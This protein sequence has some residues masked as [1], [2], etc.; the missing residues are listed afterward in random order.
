MSQSSMFEML[1]TRRLL[2]GNVTAGFNGGTNTF[3]V[4]GDNK[5]NQIVVEAE[6]G[7]YKVTGVN[8]TTVNNSTAPQFIPTPGLTNLAVSLGNGEDDLLLQPG[9]TI[10]YLSALSVK[11]D[12]GN[13]DDNVEV[14]FGPAQ[15]WISNDLNISTG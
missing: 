15:A 1:E 8:G 6:T 12:T 11:V 4:N 13:G 3:A 5:A 7:G 9:S 14:H 2:A 10:G